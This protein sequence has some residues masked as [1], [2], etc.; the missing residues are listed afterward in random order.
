MKRFS[1][2]I[3]FLL[4]AVLCL[5]GCAP[6]TTQE[7][8]LDSPVP[9][10]ALA[11]FKS[12]QTKYKATM[13]YS[14]DPEK[15][16]T[17]D[18]SYLEFMLTES[19]ENN[20]TVCTLTTTMSITYK[21]NC[22]LIPEA[23]WGKTDTVTSTSKFRK[24]TFAAIEAHKEVKNQTAPELDYSFDADYNEG[25]AHYTDGKGER[26]INFTKGNY[27][28]NEYV[29][30]Y[31]RSLKSTGTPSGTATFN[32]VNWYECFKERNNKFFTLPMAT[33][34][35][36]NPLDVKIGSGFPIENFEQKNTESSA[37]PCYATLI[38]LNRT[39]TGQPIETYYASTVYN[40]GE[41]P[42]IKQTRKMLAKIVTHEYNTK[43][44]YTYTLEYVLENFE[45]LFA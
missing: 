31:V 38:S 12:E 30:F 22:D 35:S 43:G 44:E 34:T 36:Q 3:L 19:E 29:F 10:F 16:V 26:T 33:A 5:S 23:Y 6:Q 15:P 21:D 25:V 24:K 9:W 42:I 11:G 4:T 41:S 39:Q 28:D 1:V 20:D 2:I 18:G 32:L 13:Y 14:N 27:I 8:E 17:E 7:P 40:V 37:I 45:T